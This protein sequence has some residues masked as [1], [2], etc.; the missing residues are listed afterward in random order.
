[1]KSES[2]P[3]WLMMET[4]ALCADET[5]GRVKLSKH[6]PD[7]GLQKQQLCLIHTQIVQAQGPQ[8]RRY[9]QLSL[10]AHYVH[11]SHFSVACKPM[12]SLWNLA[13]TERNFS[14]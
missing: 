2:L 3:E 6:E 8:Q 13:W 11:F 9:L 10:S 7:L 5:T 4:E 1:M 14:C 12:N